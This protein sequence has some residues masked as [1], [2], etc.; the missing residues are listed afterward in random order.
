MKEWGGGVLAAGGSGGGAGSGRGADSKGDNENATD[1][2]ERD[3]DDVKGKD[4]VIVS[5]FRLFTRCDATGSV[6][7]PC[8]L[9]TVGDDNNSCS[10]SVSSSTD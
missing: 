7:L 8:L 10:S 6:N 3:D 9:L 4:E 5:R 2:K 1:F